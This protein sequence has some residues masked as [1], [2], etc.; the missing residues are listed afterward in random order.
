[1]TLPDDSAYGA[2]EVCGGAASGD[3]RI[4]ADEGVGRLLVDQAHRNAQLLGHG[5]DNLG[6]DTLYRTK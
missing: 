2:D 3:D 5:L 6:V 4:R 1:M